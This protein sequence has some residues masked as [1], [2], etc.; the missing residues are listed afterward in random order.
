MHWAL[1][2]LRIRNFEPPP[3]RQIPFDISLTITSCP[4]AHI[5]A[6]SLPTSLPHH[7]PHHC[8]KF[9][10]HHE[11]LVGKS[12]ACT[13]MCEWQSLSQRVFTCVTTLKPFQLEQRFKPQVYT[14]TLSPRYLSMSLHWSHQD[15]IY[16]NNYYWQQSGMH[17]VKG[18]TR[19]DYDWIIQT[20]ASTT[21]LQQTLKSNYFHFHL[22]LHSL[23]FGTT[24]SSFHTLQP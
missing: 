22:A 20:W 23:H 11:L 9:W 7:Y 24:Q 18:K 8:A 14:M 3:Q 12:C 2:C 15:K 6:T 10:W 17:K 16:W 5:T 19:I 1:C 13:Q 4:D 21:T